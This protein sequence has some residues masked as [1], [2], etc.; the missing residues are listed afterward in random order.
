MTVKYSR[1]KSG[2]GKFK[3][4]LAVA[5][6]AA[7]VIAGA[8]N[9]SDRTGGSGR[10][11]RKTNERGT[12]TAATSLEGSRDLPE[13]TGEV[14][15]TLN[16][17]EP[18]FTESE[19]EEARTSYEKYGALDRHGRCTGAVASVS[20]DTMPA[21]DEARGD[22]SMVHPTGWRSGQGWERMHLIA[23]CLTDENANCRNLVT[24]TH[25][26]NVD[27]MEPFES[28]VARYID[29]TG[30]HVLYR[31]TPIYRGKDQICSG[32]H[33]EAYSV[34]DRGSGVC[35][36][37]YCFNVSP[38]STIDYRTGVV[39]NKGAVKDESVRTY[40]LNTNTMKFHYPSCSSVAAMSP[41][42]RRTVRASRSELIREGY[43]PCG[44][45]EP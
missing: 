32:I 4:L 6:L 13:Y 1:G 3:I 37:I 41:A 5:L 22:I 27:G 21:A 40:V 16:G 12:G 28:A 7:I 15:V 38:G 18:G 29:R 33:M 31:T 42:N 35:F 24:G 8:V 9:L 19:I 14:Y 39:T 10:D 23:W 34:E 43:A 45:C 36:N 2:S 25:Y 44:A 30:N 26:C 17:N 20:K 11:V